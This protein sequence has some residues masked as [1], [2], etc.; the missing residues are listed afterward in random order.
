MLASTVQFSNNDQTPTREP[1]EDN[2]HMRPAS[3]RKRNI[4]PSG[5]NSV[6][7]PPSGPRVP[8]PR[9]SSTDRPIL[10]VPNSQRSTHELALRNIRPKLPCA[11]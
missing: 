10:D 1:S 2:P 8:R 5:P 7:D 6:P 9:R 11:P 4:V 3:T